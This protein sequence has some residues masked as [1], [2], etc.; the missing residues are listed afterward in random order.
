MLNINNSSLSNTSYTNAA[1]S[2]Q[3]NTQNNNSL[4][5]NS[6][7]NATQTDT[8]EIS[9]ESAVNIAKAKDA[10]S[11]TLNDF[12][13]TTFG[14]YGDMTGPLAEIN[15]LLFLEGKT[16]LLDLS[17]NPN[18]SFIDYANSLAAS[19][20]ENPSLVPSNFLD[21]CSELKSNLEAANCK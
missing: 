16:S 7:V 5:V 18:M 13:N 8:L 15:D 9:S 11:K 17:S 3:I 21:F 2:T 14:M 1:A 12:K 19:A 10:I 6:T 20:K 4:N